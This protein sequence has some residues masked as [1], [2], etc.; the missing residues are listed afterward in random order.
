MTLFWWQYVCC[1]NGKEETVAG[2]LESKDVF[3]V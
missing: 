3:A 1:M 2:V